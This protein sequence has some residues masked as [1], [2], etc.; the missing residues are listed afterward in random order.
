MLHLLLVLYIG[1]STYC[2]IGV[3]NSYDKLLKFD[4]VLRLFIRKCPPANWFA[5]SMIL[6]VSY[7]WPVG[8][9]I[10]PLIRT[11]SF[12]YYGLHVKEIKNE[13]RYRKDR[14]AIAA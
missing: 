8:I 3:L 6:V 7:F 4:P 13:R 9:V 12:T 2:L 11:Q 14:L 5:L 1:I 10:A